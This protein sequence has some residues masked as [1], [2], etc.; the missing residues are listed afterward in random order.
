MGEIPVAKENS[1]NRGNKL[2]QRAAAREET[3][4]NNVQV[5]RGEE[6]DDFRARS[7]PGTVIVGCKIPNGLILQLTTWES[8]AEPVMGGGHRDVKVGRKT[9]DRYYVRGP[10]IPYGTV[11]LFSMSG[12]YALTHGIPEDFW[13]KWLEENKQQTYVKRELIVAHKA[14]DYVQEQCYDN[15]DVLTGLEPIDPENLPRGVQTPNHRI[16]VADEMKKRSSVRL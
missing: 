13:E 6:R 3:G 2:E 16:E 7:A 5:A 1:G 11:A 14:L 10:R 4:S 15:R 12:G 8:Q 9:G